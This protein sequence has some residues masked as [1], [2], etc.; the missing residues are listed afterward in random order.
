MV[1]EHDH[2]EDQHP[3][4]MRHE[5]RP[6]L[7]PRRF[8]RCRHDLVVLGPVC[9]GEHIEQPAALLDIVLPLGHPRRHQPRHLAAVADEIKLRCLVVVHVDDDIPPAQRLPHAHEKS[10]IGLLVDDR[11]L[12][13]RRPQHMPAHAERPVALVELHIIDRRS[14]RRPRPAVARIDDRLAGILARRDVADRDG[15][16]LRPL[17]VGG[18][19]QQ[20]VIGRMLRPAEPEIGLARLDVAVEQDCLLATLAWRPHDD[21][22]LLA[23]LG[24]RI[25]RPRP[26]G[27]GQL[28]LV[29]LDAPADLPIDRVDQRLAGRL[30]RRREI[31]VLGLEIG[32]DVRRQRLGRLHHLL[33]VVGAQPR[34][35]VLPGHP[36]LGDGVLSAFGDGRGGGNCLGHGR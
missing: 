19:G 2:V 31:A 7:G 32:A 20:P 10:G 8:R 22:I 1:G 6:V 36:V 26:V 24:T 3:R 34:I 35:R 28:G 11:V 16:I 30:E 33:P 12:G 14:I 23:L 21:G 29:L 15:V 5:V 4:H 25:V 17:P 18:P 13:L 9:I 27:I